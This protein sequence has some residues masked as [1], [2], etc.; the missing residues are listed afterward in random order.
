MG[1]RG[2]NCGVGVVT[3]QTPFLHPVDDVI[4]TIQMII[5]ESSSL[6]ICVTVC[7]F[8]SSL[9]NLKIMHSTY[10]TLHNNLQNSFSVENR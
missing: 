8:N 6:I 3:S 10:S 7:A 4:S 5:V 9:Q 1:A 2:S